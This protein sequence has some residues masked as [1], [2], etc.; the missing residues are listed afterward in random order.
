MNVL[1]FDMIVTKFELQSKYWYTFVFNFLEKVQ[2]HLF[3]IY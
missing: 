3:S 1:E 2:T